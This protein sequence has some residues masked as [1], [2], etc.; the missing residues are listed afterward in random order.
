MEIFK[1]GDN[2]YSVVFGWGKVKEIIAND[3][4]PIRVDF[5]CGGYH[6]TLDGRFFEDETQILSFTE[7]TLQGFSQERPIVLPEVGELCL[8]RDMDSD[9]WRVR[10]FE[11]EHNGEFYCTALCGSTESY[12]KLKR[13]KILD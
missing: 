3:K 11:F 8:V 7:Y 4:Y 13:I 1:K 12:G 6:F 2:V 10:K 9:N 5:K